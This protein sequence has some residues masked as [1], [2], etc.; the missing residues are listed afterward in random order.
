MSSRQIKLVPDLMHVKF[1]PSET[2][3]IPA[4]LQAVPVLAAAVVEI[5]ERSPKVKIIETI[6][7]ERFMELE[8]EERNSI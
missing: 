4:F 5:K 2:D 1:F 8:Y 6:D 7:A 3:F